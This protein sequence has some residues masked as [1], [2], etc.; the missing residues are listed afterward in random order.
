[1]CR[2]RLENLFLHRLELICCP[3]LE[4]LAA[5]DFETLAEGLEEVLRGGILRYLLKEP[6]GGCGLD[7]ILGSGA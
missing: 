5:F 4:Q 2:P 6:G 3:R 1:M 7:A